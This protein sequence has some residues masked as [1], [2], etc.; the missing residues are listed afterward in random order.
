MFRQ[1]LDA[2]AAYAALA[3]HGS[4]LTALQFRHERGANTEDSEIDADLPKTIRIEKRGDVFT[5]FVSFGG[6]PLHPV[7]ASTRLHLASPY[8]LGLGALSHDVDTT[9][10]VKFSHVTLTRTAA[11]TRSARVTY[12]TVETIQIEDQYRRA[13][14]LHSEPAPLKSVNWIAGG[15]FLYV[16]ADGRLERIGTQAPLV[17]VVP[18]RVSLGKLSDC[19]GNY[20]LS[21]DG[22]WLAISCRHGPPDGTRA[23]GPDATQVYVLPAD[24]GDPVRALTSAPTGSYFHA[25]SA[26][27]RVIAFTRGSASHADIFTVPASGGAES[28]LTAD[29]VNDGPDF[30]PDGKFIYFDSARSGTL[31]IWRMHMDGSAP[32]QITDDDHENSSPHVSPDGKHLAFLSQPPRSGPGVGDAAIRVMAF[33]DGLI[34]TVVDFQGD[35]DS[36]SMY[37]W[38]DTNHLGFVSYQSLP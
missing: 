6:E 22:K 12:S 8:Y 29:T 20:G 7:G 19:S 33:E 25:W 32:E 16:D 18:E 37:S 3:V 34:R 9:D 14:V 15:Q 10:E 38:G 1:S 36:F 17:G 31:Q 35:R 21:P 23:G 30:S 28:R 24:G 26:D 5:A 4:G 27:S 11:A 13:A 2:G